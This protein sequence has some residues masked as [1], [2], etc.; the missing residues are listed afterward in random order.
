MLSLRISIGSETVKAL[1]AKLQQAYRAGDAGLVKRV[2]AL[3]RISRHEPAE[4]ICQELGCSQSSWYDWLKKVVY[5][6]VDRLE[7]Q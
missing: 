2:T 5:E 6:G 1:Q 7:V 3:L 4:V